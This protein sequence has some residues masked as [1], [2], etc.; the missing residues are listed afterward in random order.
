MIQSENDKL[1]SFIKLRNDYINELDQGET[2]KQ[3]FNERNDKL[4]I[5]LNLKPFSILDTFEKALFNYNYYNTKAKIALFNANKYREQK[6]DRK[7]KREL[8]LKNNYYDE[9]DKASVAMIKLEDPEKIEAYYINLH[10]RNLASSIFEVYFKAR[11]KVILHSKSEEIKEL[12]I[13]LGVFKD[14]VRDSIID[15]Y[16]NKG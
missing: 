14:E 3:E 4:Y 6:K 9:K 11:E 1:K 7:Y 2:S 13:S 10:S 12:L 15:S 8:N 5:E 16:V